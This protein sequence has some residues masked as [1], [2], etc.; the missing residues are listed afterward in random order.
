MIKRIISL[1]CAWTLVYSPM[2]FA[3]ESTGT[4]TQA[5]F[6]AMANSA[7]PMWNPDRGFAAWSGSSINTSWSTPGTSGDLGTDGTLS[8]VMCHINLGAFR[9]TAIDQ[10][11]LDLLQ[12]RLNTVHSQGRKCVV[13]IWYDYSSAGNDATASRIV[14]H[15]NQLGTASGTWLG[16]KANADRIAFY[17][18]GFIGAWGEWHSSKNGNSC[19]YNSGTT[20]CATAAANRILVRNAL[21]ANI[22]PLTPIQYRYPA[23]VAI[24]YPTV[25]SANQAFNGSAQS[26]THVANDCQL[27]A[28]NDTGTWGSNNGGSSGLGVTGEQTYVNTLGDRASYG[29]ELS[30]CNEPRRT[31]CA[32]AV[33]P[34]GDFYKYNL[35]WIKDTSNT[36]DYLAGWTSGGCVNEINNLIG[37]RL[38]Y[39]GVTHQSTASAGQTVTF[40]VSIRNVGWSRVQYPRKIQVVMVR[41]GGGASNVT[42]NSR[43]DLRALPPN[44]GS[45]NSAITVNC[46]TGIAGTWNVHL[47]L[48]DIWPNNTANNFTIRPANTDGGGASWDATNYRWTT[49]TSIVV[50]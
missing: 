23:D 24:W 19:N 21:L 26:R 47:K 42:C 35:T 14:S 34:S 50:S 4:P 6:T 45:T 12:T 40:T 44:A 3:T 18:A 25:L 10:T 29:G 30:A 31:S 36:A 11:T 15:L 48:P 1:L 8:L 13:F 5:T 9:T 20:T 16:L 46:T 38:I 22:H 7:T 2:A 39:G 37:Y 41:S 17:K 33:G 27:S 28:N 32:D 49:G 43:V